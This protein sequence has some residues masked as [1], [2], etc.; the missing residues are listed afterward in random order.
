VS[1]EHVLGISAASTSLALAMARL[2]SALNE[3]A[4]EVRD[5]SLHEPVAGE[6]FD[7]IVSNPPSVVSPGTDAA[8]VY[9]DSGLPG[10]EVVRR[11]VSQSSHHLNEAGWCQVLANWAHRRG[12][13][14]QERVER[15]IPGDCDAWVLQRERVDLPTYV[16]MW[17]TD[18]GAHGAPGYVRRYD[19]WLRWFDEQGIEAVG[20]GWLSLR[21]AGRDQPVRRLEEWPYEMEQPVGLSVTGWAERTDRLPASDADLLGLRLNQP[22][23]L[24]QETVGEPGSVDPERILLRLQRG[25]RRARQVDTVEAGFVGACDGDLT[26]GQLLDALAELTRADATDL[27]AEYLPRVRALV[28][29]GYLDRA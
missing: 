13:D 24:A 6:R 27:R 9:R 16:E 4:Y 29:D 8:L 2:T 3:V 10:D 1:T 26:V 17:L 15:W 12:E 19:R 23:G 18:A 5:G 21:R 22:E 14:W 7:L 25:V 28:T 20:F 11:V